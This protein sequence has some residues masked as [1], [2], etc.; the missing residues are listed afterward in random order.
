MSWKAIATLIVVVLLVAAGAGFV[1][2]SRIDTDFPSVRAKSD[3]AAVRQ[4]LGNPATIQGS[5]AAY[6][7]FVM[8]GCDHVFIYRSIFYPL[9]SKYWLVFF[10]K[11]QQ[12]TATSGQMEP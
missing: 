4:L 1:R 9:R 12:V 3:E 7:T 11:N 2:D 5:C 6:D 10:D 8:P